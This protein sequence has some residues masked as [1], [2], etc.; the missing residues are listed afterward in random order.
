MSNNELCLEFLP[1]IDRIAKHTWIPEMTADDI[2]DELALTLLT[3]KINFKGKNGAS[4]K[5]YVRAILKN[6]IK[7]LLRK[8]GVRERY[9]MYAYELP[10]YVLN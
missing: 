5:T 3:R 4:L 10:S 1:L 9:E 6:R 2:K 8:A 7:D